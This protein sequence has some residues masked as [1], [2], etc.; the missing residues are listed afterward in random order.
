LAVLTLIIW[1]L[2]ACILMGVFSFFIEYI[3]HKNGTAD[4]FHFVAPMTVGFIAYAAWKA[5]RISVHNTITHFIMVVSTISTFLL[6]KTPWIFPIVIVL[7][8]IVTN[9]SSKRIPQTEILTRK[10][11]WA[12][13]WLFAFIFILAGV[14]SELARKNN[15]PHRRPINL[16]ENTYRAGSL[17]FGG[18]QVLIPFMYE[19]FVARPESQKLILR[20]PNIVKINKEDFYTGAG[21]VRAIPGPVF[22]V[23]SY[24]GGI[25]M[26]DMGFTMQVLGCVIGSLAIFLPSALLVLFFFP[27]WSNLKK[28]ATVYR[29]LEGINAVVVGIMVASSFY[30]MKEF[31]PGS[32]LLLWLD[33]GVGILTFILLMYSRLPSPVIVMI[34]LL[35]GWIV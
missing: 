18:G 11:K 28:Y 6:F 22:S 15:W 19:Q 21:F 13:I 10:I 31:T 12:N 35:L 34:C 27:I 23:S 33:I 5:F 25:A 32:P 26:K 2:P 14:S 8:G 17:V 9:L 4:L 16:F 30:M 29:A 24:M 20:N 3:N 1:I 7:G